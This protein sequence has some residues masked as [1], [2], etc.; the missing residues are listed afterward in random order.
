MLILFT[1]TEASLLSPLF[2]KT[3]LQLSILQDL[4]Q[5]FLHDKTGNIGENLGLPWS[6]F[7]K[8]IKFRPN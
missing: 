5:A 7:R 6:K 1:I 3:N 4:C 2:V 8:W